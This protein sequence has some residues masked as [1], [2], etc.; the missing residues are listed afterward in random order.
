VAAE[1]LLHRGFNLPADYVIHTV[2]PI[3]SC[4]EESAPLLARAYANSVAE[5]NRLVGLARHFLFVA[6]GPPIA[7]TTCL[8]K[9]FLGRALLVG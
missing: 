8:R 2:G 3:Y 7:I 1:C 9:H 4:P 5:A 6:R